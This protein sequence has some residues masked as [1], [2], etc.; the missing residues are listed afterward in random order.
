MSEY[1]N[2]V[3]DFSELKGWR[4]PGEELKYLQGALLDN[5]V[6]SKK[7]NKYIDAIFIVSIPLCIS[8][9][10]SIIST[11]TTQIRTMEMFDIIL[12]LIGLILVCTWGIFSITQFKRSLFSTEGK[13]IKLVKAGDFSVC[14]A[15]IRDIHYARLTQDSKDYMM[16][17]VSDKEDTYCKDSITCDWTRWLSVGSHVY[18]TCYEI[19][20]G[21]YFYKLYP[22]ISNGE[23]T[24]CYE[25]GMKLYHK[26]MV[27]K[28]SKIGRFFKT[29]CMRLVIVFM[30][31]SAFGGMM[32]VANYRSGRYAQIDATITYVHYYTSDDT[33]KANGYIRW[34]YDG[35]VFTNE[36]DG[37]YMDFK[38]D[39]KIGDRKTI[40]IDTETGE[41]ESEDG[42]GTSLSALIFSGVILIYLS[43]KLQ[44]MAEENENA[45]MEL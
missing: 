15:T 43:R 35:K 6:D 42:M 24:E 34:E 22:S 40:W 32:D 4:R 23:N 28:E 26:F 13:Y 19:E 37:H 36:D 38:S 44:L 2:T 8:G 17:N 33:D 14:D 5:L 1:K 12:F 7:A 16:A 31:I 27:K 18:I 3:D 39:A 9:V 29:T 25:Y 41:F 11:L 30:C 20:E 10:I 21:R 45:N